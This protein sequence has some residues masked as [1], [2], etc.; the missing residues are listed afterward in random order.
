MSI[1]FKV[2]HPGISRLDR[3]SFDRSLHYHIASVSDVC[4]TDFLVT[5]D[6]FKLSQK[7]NPEEDFLLQN[8]KCY[9]VSS[10]SQFCLSSTHYNN[11]VVS[12]WFCEMMSKLYIQ[13]KNS[14]S[15]CLIFSPSFPSLYI[16]WLTWDRSTHKNLYIP[17]MYVC[18]CWHFCF[19]TRQQHNKLL[20]NESAIKLN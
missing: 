9:W 4:L 12:L 14:I 16:E 17:C 7:E 5:T 13:L 15:Y 6:L 18:E 8:N 3:S 10:A 1:Q 2:L 11:F 20:V 19:T